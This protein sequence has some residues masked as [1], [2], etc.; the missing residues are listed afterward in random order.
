MQNPANASTPCKVL[1][2]KELQS[3]VAFAGIMAGIMAI[4]LFAPLV[5][6]GEVLT[7]PEQ[8]ILR[9]KD[10]MALVREHN[11]FRWH[12]H[13]LSGIERSH[14]LIVWNP[15]IISSVDAQYWSMPVLN[16]L[17]RRICIMPLSLSHIAPW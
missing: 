7:M 3:R 6:P 8:C 9:L 13:Q 11:Q 5:Q 10:P 14:T 17:I 2:I 1:I 12:A 15:E 4:L 16:Q